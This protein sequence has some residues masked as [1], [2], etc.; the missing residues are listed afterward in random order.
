MT[1]KTKKPEREMMSLTFTCPPECEE[2][3]GLKEVDDIPRYVRKTT[4]VKDR[5]YVQ[6][7]GLQRGSGLRSLCSAGC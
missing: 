4:Q 6:V 1:K 7:A 2:H 3:D 5:H